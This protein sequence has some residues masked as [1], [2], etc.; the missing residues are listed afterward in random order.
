MLYTISNRKNRGARKKEEGFITLQNE[1]PFLLCKKSSMDQSKIFI[2]FFLTKELYGE[3]NNH[4][5]LAIV[6]RKLKSWFKE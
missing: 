6:N 4:I 5:I 2:S 3:I 1:K